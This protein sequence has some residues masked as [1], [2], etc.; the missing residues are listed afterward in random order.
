MPHFT[1][2]QLPIR[3]PSLIVISFHVLSLALAKQTLTMLVNIAMAMI[4]VKNFAIN[5]NRLADAM[6]EK[7]MFQ[8][9]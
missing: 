5:K 3:L 9:V 6:F 8:F 2:I 7:I 1:Q 4:F